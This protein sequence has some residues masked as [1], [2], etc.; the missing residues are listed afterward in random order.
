M[1]TWQMPG[2]DQN[3]PAKKL[4]SRGGPLAEIGQETRIKCP[5]PAPKGRPLQLD[6]QEGQGTG[7]W[8]IPVHTGEVSHP[9]QARGQ[10]ALSQES[11]RLWRP[12]RDYPPSERPCY[13]NLNSSGRPEKMSTF[14]RTSPGPGQARTSERLPCSARVSRDV[15][16]ALKLKL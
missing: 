9:S 8:N 12:S 1:D 11:S 2:Q 14:R 4:F 6:S 13:R 10:G 3:P 7:D 16:S 5:R 15:E